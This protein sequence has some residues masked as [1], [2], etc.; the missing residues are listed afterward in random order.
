M[1]YILITIIVLL[2]IA[3][4]CISID[5]N[6]EKSNH[7]K[8]MQEMKDVIGMMAN[9]GHEK[10]GMIKLSDDLNIS[11][12][13]ARKTLDNDILAMQYDLVETLSKNDLVG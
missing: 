11:L 9:I 12:T 8:K 3:I 5:F 4:V 13:T 10:A 1:I 7:D 2:S 6:R